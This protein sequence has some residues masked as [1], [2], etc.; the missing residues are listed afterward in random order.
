MPEVNRV[1]RKRLEGARYATRRPR[2]ATKPRD[3]VNDPFLSQD[4]AAQVGVARQIADV[5]FH[6]AAIDDDGPRRRDRKR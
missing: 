2:A 5:A 6:E 3:V 1:L 4:E